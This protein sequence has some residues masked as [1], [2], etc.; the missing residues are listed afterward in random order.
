MTE[1]V[2][3]I[4]VVIINTTFLLREFVKN[5]ILSK[6]LESAQEELEIKTIEVINLEQFMGKQIRELR[7]TKK[8]LEKRLIPEK[9]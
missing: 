7:E 2:F 5:A 6:R 8:R 1:T 3:F 9:E 4:G